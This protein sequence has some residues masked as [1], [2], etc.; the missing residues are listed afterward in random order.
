VP[1]AGGGLPPLSAPE[2]ELARGLT[3]A[4]SRSFVVRGST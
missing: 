4:K 2:P 1:S 3:K